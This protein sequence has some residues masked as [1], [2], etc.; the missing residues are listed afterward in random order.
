MRAMGQQMSDDITARVI[1]SPFVPR[2]WNALVDAN[3]KAICIVVISPVFR[4][5]FGNPLDERICGV[6][7]NMGALADMAKQQMQM[8]ALAD[9]DQTRAIKQ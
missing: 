9:W 3:G 2:N 5:I 8:A 6:K 1:G 4:V 7:I